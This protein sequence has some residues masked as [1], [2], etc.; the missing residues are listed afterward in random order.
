MNWRSRIGFVV[1]LSVLMATPAFASVGVK[2]KRDGAATAVADI[3]STSLANNLQ[4]DGSASF[5][6]EKRVNLPL[7]AFTV[8]ASTTSALPLTNSS[9]PG[10]A[11][12]TAAEGQYIKFANGITSPIQVKFR[13]PADYASGG[14]FRVLIGRSGVTSSPPQ[15]GFA[16]Y[17]DA[18]NT[19]F[20]TTATSQTAVAVST[21]VG[22]GSPVEKTLT[23]VT[24]FANLAAGQTVTLEL[25]RAAVGTEDLEL[26]NAEFYYQAQD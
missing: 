11:A 26:Y 10:L 15:I 21:T 24:D 6:H 20:S 9:S 16:V 5:L 2:T 7:A 14:I 22:S 3:V 18:D 19:A 8:R 13:I 23:V 1:G 4:T 12:K 25:S 17:I